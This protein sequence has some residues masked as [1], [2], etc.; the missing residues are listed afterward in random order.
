MSKEEQGQSRVHKDSYALC[1]HL[2]VN[3]VDHGLGNY[4][5]LFP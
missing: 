3:T 1:C 4:Q 5:Q 2:G